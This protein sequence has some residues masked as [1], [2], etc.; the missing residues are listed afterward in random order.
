MVAPKEVRD[1]VERFKL[2]IDAYKRATYN[3]TQLRREFIDPL[4]KVLGWDIDNVQGYAE[5]Y[6]GVVHE[7]SLKIGGN[8]KAPDYAFRI[9]GT[10]KF[11]LEAK[12]PSVNI[13][14][15]IHPAYQ[16]RRYAWSAKLPLSI[17][18]DFEEFAVYDCRVKP[19]NDDKA[20]VARIKYYTYEDY[21]NAWD[22]IASIFSRE[23]ILKGSFDKYAESNRGKKGTAEVDDAFLEEI[24]NWREV[25]ARNIALR[26]PNLSVRELNTAVQR[27]VDRIIFLRIAEDRGIEK[28]GQ[29][30]E[31][32]AGKNIYQ[33]LTKLFR[34]AD[35]RYNSGLFHFKKGD[36]FVE[37]LDTFTLDLTID[38]KAIKS[39]LKGLYYPDSPYEF[40]VL[41]ADILGQVY[42]RFLGKVIRFSGKRAV[43]EEKPE[44]KKA[45]GIYYTP[46]Y[47]VRFIVENSV[48][49]LLEGLTPD[50]LSGKTQGKH[51][52]RILDPACGSGSFLIEAYQYLMDWYRDQYVAAGPTKFAQR[53]FR[54]GLSG[55]CRCDSRK[56]AETDLEP[57]CGR[58]PPESSIAARRCVIRLI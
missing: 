12:K 36:G 30:Q 31:L 45:G 41:P 11:F 8:T 50:Q 17:L 33:R 37:T 2:H 34:A 57:P 26:N 48:R 9:G 24:E 56:V 49:P 53:P 7:D 13:K 28:Y 18:T 32:N 6:K 35:D 58:R 23:A 54:K 5:A 55:R 10:R 14:D 16:L 46:N 1:L 22:D 38:D 25:L 52:L 40:S 4:F 3:E 42:E 15:D 21:L 39:I 43:I 27:T 44:I 47:I 20:S 19:K 51:P 29:L